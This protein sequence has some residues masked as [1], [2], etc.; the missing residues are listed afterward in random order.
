MFSLIEA[1][2]GKGLKLY[3]YNL[4]DDTCR[5]VTIVANTQWGGKNI[6][7]NYS[8]ENVILHIFIQMKFQVKEVWDVVSDMVTCTGYRLK[9]I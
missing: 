7:E 1:H 8:K 9:R 2:E 3:V 5:E 4:D 6:F